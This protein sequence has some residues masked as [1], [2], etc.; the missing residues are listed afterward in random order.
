MLSSPK[1]WFIFDGMQALLAL[2]KQSLH[3]SLYQLVDNFW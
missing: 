2:G 3:S 1:N